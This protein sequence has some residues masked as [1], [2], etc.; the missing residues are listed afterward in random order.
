M[1]GRWADDRNEVEQP[2]G[3]A[4]EQRIRDAGNRERHGHDRYE[5]DIDR[6]QREEV[7]RNPHAHVADDARHAQTLGVV[8]RQEHE[9][10][11]VAGAKGQQ[12]DRHH[13]DIEQLGQGG[14]CE[15]GQ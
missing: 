3:D 9:L 1:Q 14:R 10:L 6:R 15:Q 7:A 13:G 4:P 11:A 2:V 12:E 5:A 8:A